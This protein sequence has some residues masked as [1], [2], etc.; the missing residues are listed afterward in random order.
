M[1][2]FMI[3]PTVIS[4]TSSALDS[5]D[6]NFLISPI[7]LGNNKTQAIYKVYKKSIRGK[8]I[9]SLVVA[10]SRAIGETMAVSMILQSQNYNQIFN[11]GF[12]AV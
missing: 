6:R 11:S 5:V 12:L 2:T 9:I 7:L 1:L 10:A 4:L 3:V 8:I